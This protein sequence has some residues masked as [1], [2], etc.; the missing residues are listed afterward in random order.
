MEQHFRVT[1]IKRFKTMTDV[2]N[3]LRTLNVRREIVETNEVDAP[4]V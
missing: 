3:Y 4:N 2:K 1:Y